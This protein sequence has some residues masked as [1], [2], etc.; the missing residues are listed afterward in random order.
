MST[1][2]ELPL[3]EA[4]A[5]AGITIAGRREP[6]H[7]TVQAGVK[8]HY[9][10][11]GSEDEPWMLCIH[12][13]AQNAH[14]WDF[15]ALAFCDRY[16][17]VAIDQRGHGDSEWAPDAD[18]GRDA[19]VD[20]ISQAVD[21]LGMTSFVLVGLSLG[22]SNSVAY[23]A[24][25]PDRVNALI[26][27]DVGPETA[28]RGEQ[29]VNN[30]VTQPDVLDSFDE[31]VQRVMEYSPHRPE[32]QV[33]SSLRHN[34]RELPDGR[35]TWKYDPVLRDPARRADR[36]STKVDP[37]SRWALWE[38][39]ACPTLIVRGEH[40]NMLSSEVAGRMVERNPNSSFVEVPN[41]GHRVPGDNP[42]AFE[43]GVRAFLDGLDK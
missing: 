3:V 7:R 35:L 21:R 8:L 16:H 28:G 33:R 34:L 1:E 40:S 20:D 39:V 4:A 19:Y 32:W 25:N 12:G 17:I 11:W 18:Y 36:L 14:M 5:R 15:T 43:S 6:T 2:M 31:F 29:S 42:V 22:G 10:D 27:V 30:F 38:Q 9:L 37:A 24:A 26:V 13:S 23:A 41:A